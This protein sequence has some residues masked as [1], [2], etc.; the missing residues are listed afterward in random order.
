MLPQAVPAGIANEPC[1]PTPFMHLQMAEAIGSHADLHPAARDLLGANWPGFYMG[2]VAPDVQTV[3]R[4]PRD[5]THFYDLPPE[6]DEKAYAKM[7]ACYPSLNSNSLPPNK[8]AFVAAYCAHLMLDLRWYHEVLIPY[9]VDPPSWNDNHQRFVV[10]NTLLTFLDRSAAI[11]LPS[12]AAQTLAS[13]DKEDWLPFVKDE[14]LMKW[15]DI[16]VDQLRPGAPLRTI[17]IYAGRL[18]MSPE[19]F[20]ANLNEPAWMD[21]HLF[22]RVPVLKVKETLALTVPESVKLIN[23][24]LIE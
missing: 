7:L 18:Y 4:V 17:E 10:H 6:R 9:F 3:S 23:D 22:Q 13:V 16:L 14:D 2:S 1:M 21:E 15:R 19:E 11:S 5:Q 12:G 20:A 24:Y 8:A